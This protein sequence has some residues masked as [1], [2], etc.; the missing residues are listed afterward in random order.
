MSVQSIKSQ[1]PNA[2]VRPQFGTDAS[3]PERTAGIVH[4]AVEP[5]PH[6][7]KVGMFV[8]TPHRQS[9]GLMGVRPSCHMQVFLQQKWKRKVVC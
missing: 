5:L 7:G 3:G 6:L 4:V 2:Q 1:V 8:G 9:H